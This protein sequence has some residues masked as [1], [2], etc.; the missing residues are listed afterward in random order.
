MSYTQVST[1]LECPLEYRLRY[2]ERLPSRPKGYFSFGNTLH[3]CLAFYFQKKRP[4]AVASVLQ[5]YEKVW[6]SQGYASADDEVR[7]K[8]LGIKILTQFCQDHEP[9][10]RRSLATEHSFLVD[11]GGV[12]LKGVIDRVDISESGGLCIMDYKSGKDFP[13]PQAMEDDL[14]LT[15]YQLAA[16]SLWL[17]PA[18]KL[19][20]YHLR[21]NMP[22][23]CRPRGQ[24][25]LEEARQTVFV[26]QEGIR[27]KE[28][29]ARRHRFCPC[30][31]PQR[32]PHF[33]RSQGVRQASG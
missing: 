14:Q 15:L 11:L 24:D 26:V 22:I 4:P 13:S 2:I 10:Y 28:F 3:R 23:E 30:D 6:S 9:V 18:E 1:Y 16:Q 32:C 7:D 17:L 8:A 27:R 33:A 25:R 21:Y 20:I 19:V 5:F 12:S 29:P 31:Y